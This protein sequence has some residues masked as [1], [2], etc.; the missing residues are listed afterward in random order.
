MAEAVSL[1]ALLVAYA[2]TFL[3]ALPAHAAFQKR[4]WTRYWHYALLGISLGAAP[5]L[6]FG[7]YVLLAAPNPAREIATG[8]DDAIRWLTLGSSCGLAAASLFWVLAV[9]PS[10]T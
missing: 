10:R 3:A 1:V 5:F 8:A 4:N 9:R 6:A 7:I 2:V